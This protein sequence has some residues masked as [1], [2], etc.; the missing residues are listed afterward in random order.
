MGHNKAREVDINQGHLYIILFIFLSTEANCGK[1]EPN[2]RML[3][4]K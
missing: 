4:E 2:D 1:T 3:R